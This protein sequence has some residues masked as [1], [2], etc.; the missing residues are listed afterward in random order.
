MTDDAKRAVDI[1]SARESYMRAA[2]AEADRAAALGEIPVGAVVIR[3]GSI[4]ARAHNRCR[5]DCD[6]TAHAEI[7]AL[8][9]AARARGDWRLAGCALYVTLEPCPMCAGAIALARLD[10]VWYGAPDT[11]QG[12]CGSV[13]RITEDRALGVF[14]PANGGLLADECAARLSAFMSAVRKK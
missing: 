6:P 13:Y 7:I 9:E 3:G 12:C 10:E 2:L 4:I 14:V 1:I 8:R 11:R 5:I